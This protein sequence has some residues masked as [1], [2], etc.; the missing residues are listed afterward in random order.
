MNPH[1]ITK[2]HLLKATK[3]IMVGMYAVSIINLACLDTIGNLRYTCGDEINTLQIGMP[4]LLRGRRL[5]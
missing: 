1:T 4:M 5:V 2:L 3:I